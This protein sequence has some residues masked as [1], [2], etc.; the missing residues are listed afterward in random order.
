MYASSAVPLAA[1]ISATACSGVSDFD[2]RPACCPFGAST[3]AATLWPTRSSRS[4][5]RIART[6]TLCAICTVRVDNRAAS[7]ANAP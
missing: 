5:W 2:R 4:A 7:A 1:A 6:R 3:S